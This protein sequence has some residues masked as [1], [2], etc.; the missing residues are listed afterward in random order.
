MPL[1]AADVLYML[2]QKY[3]KFNPKDTSW[4]NRDRFVLSAGHGSM[5]LYIMLHI[6]GY[7]VSMDDIRNFRQLGSKTPGHPEYGVTPGVET[8]TGPLGQGIANAVG[9]AIGY[10]ILRKK[11]T[12]RGH[13]PLNHKIYAVCGDGDIM[14]GIC[15]EAASLAGHLG[16]SNLVVI[17]DDN[18]NTIEGNTN[19]AF[20]E[21]VDA[22]FRSLGW[23]TVKIDGH[24]FG[25][26]DSA[27]K[28]ASGQNDKPFLII[29]K[30][31][32]AKGSVSFEGSHKSHGAPLG[33]EEVEKIRKKLGDNKPFTVSEEVRK[34]AAS[35]LAELKAEY[36]KW[37][38]EFEQFLSQNPDIKKE[39]HELNSRPRLEA[40][41]VSNIDFGGKPLATR[42]ASGIVMQYV[43]KQI[44]GFLGGS[45]DLGPSNNTTLKDYRPFSREDRFGRNFHYGIR[46]HSM[47]AIT[48]GIAI[49][50]N[51][52]PFAAT[53]LIFSDYMK[54]AVR[55]AALMKL[56][57]V[58]VLTHDSFFVGEDGPTHQPIEQVW[59]LRSI[60]GLDVIRPADAKET[61]YAWLQAVNN[62]ENPTA[63]ILTRQNLPQIDRSKHASAEHLLKGGYVL[64][65]ESRAGDPDL[66]IIAT[67]SEVHPALEVQKKLEAE[68]Q[69]GRL[70]VRVVNMPCLELFERQSPEYRES[71]LPKIVKKRVVIEAGL[72]GGWHKYNGIDGLAISLNDFGASGPAEILCEKYGFTADK[73]FSNIKKWLQ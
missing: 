61:A 1:G 22:K 48:N 33:A 32:I 16:L 35:R 59:G 66:I 60:P 68:G 54:P 67:G 62:T 13:S 12:A 34:H 72:T 8:S 2:W 20:S 46:E 36:D 38:K 25:Q 43:A 28:K 17:Y 53:F 6:Y 26:I 4:I 51:F 45:A 41:D 39:Y 49:C 57:V 65:G 21:D 44:P 24:D 30:T 69:A 7:D 15:S 64:S 31:V 56:H 58:Y 14:E 55:M 9:M 42:S 52:L 37:N 70:S 10:E 50:A 73:I 23:D 40:A 27:L 11:L 19:L 3:L 29:A 47:A 71:I 5:L 18:G 63:L